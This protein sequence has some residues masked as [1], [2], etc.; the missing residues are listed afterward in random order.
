[1]QKNV[2]MYRESSDDVRLF[3]EWKGIRFFALFLN[4][5]I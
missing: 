2:D 3:Q 5:A 4:I 1:M